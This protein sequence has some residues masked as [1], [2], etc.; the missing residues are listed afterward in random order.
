MLMGDLVTVQGVGRYIRKG[1]IRNCERQFEQLFE[2]ELAPADQI[3]EEQ[4]ELKKAYVD[5]LSQLFIRG[6]LRE[7]VVNDVLY[8][9]ING[10]EPNAQMLVE[11]HLELFCSLL[12][13]VGGRLSSEIDEQYVTG[14]IDTVREIAGG[15]RMVSNRTVALMRKLLEGYSSNWRR[16][17]S[18]RAMLLLASADAAAVAVKMEHQLALEQE[19]KTR[20]DDVAQLSAQL[21][22]STV[23]HQEVLDQHRAAHASEVAQLNERIRRLSA[24]AGEPSMNPAARAAASI[25]SPI[26]MAALVVGVSLAVTQVATCC[27]AN[28]GQSASQFVLN[29]CLAALLN[30]TKAAAPVSWLR[31]RPSL[32]A[33]GTATASDF[34]IG[35]HGSPAPEAIMCQGWDTNQRQRQ[36][37]GPGEYFDTD[38]HHSLASY[39]LGT[40]GVV[41]ALILRS[42]AT[43]VVPK[44]T[45]L[46][47]NNP[48]GVPGASTPTYCFPLGYVM[49]PSALPPRACTTCAAVAVASPPPG[50][51]AWTKV[52]YHQHGTWRA[53]DPGFARNV[54]A[55]VA[56]SP[57]A[58]FTVDTNQFRYKVQL[59]QQSNGTYA[60]T[61]TNTATEKRREL[62]V[63]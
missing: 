55:N 28:S 63:V 57:A 25:N 12:Q 49:V 10:N 51:A 17:V 38:M 44:P 5:L 4:N 13:N 50:V 15:R 36:A 22:T 26:E 3:E 52:E 24:S 41:V 42:K 35:F 7:T 48:T 27:G 14:Y 61:Q 40:G 8:H 11:F 20:A 31:F 1:L 16:I 23:T 62:R 6:I 34:V 60:G 29:P 33:M 18:P 37:H 32:L 43:P 58:A 46:L 2:L 53:A 47:V 54:L 39:S 56:N 59:Q 30:G 45:W 19:R 21:Q 9:L